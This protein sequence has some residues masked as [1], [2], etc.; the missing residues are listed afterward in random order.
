MNWNRAFKLHSFA[1]YFCS[2]GL[3]ALAFVLI[4]VPGLLAAECTSSEHA[5]AETCLK[6][7]TKDE[8]CRKV[9]SKGCGQARGSRPSDTCYE[10]KRNADS[11]KDEYY[12][13]CKEA[14]LSPSSCKNKM[15]VCTSAGEGDEYANDEDL[16][17]AFSEA[18][19]VPQDKIGSSCPKYSGQSFFDRKDKYQRDLDDI[20]KQLKDN[21]KELADLNKEFNDDVKKVQE[22]IAEAQKEYQEKQTEIKQNQRDRAADMAKSAADMAQNVRK[23]ETAILNK[24]QEIDTIY[25][26]K[27][28]SL[29]QITEA[30]SKR[31]CMAQ[32]REERKK[33]DAIKGGSLRSG[34]TAAA[35][36]KKQLQDLFDECMVKFDQAR[37]KLI[38]SSDA[39]IESAEKD[40]RNSQ[41]DIDSLQTQLTQMNSAEQQ[42][43]QDEA[44]TLT[45]AQTALQEKIQRATAELQSLQT[46]TQEKAKALTQEQSYLADKSKGISNQIMALGAVPNDETSTGKISDVANAHEAYRGAAVAAD[47]DGCDYFDEVGVVEKASKR[48]GGA[49]S[50]KGT[51]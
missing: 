20:N 47:M 46:T 36:K 23:L 7:D 34:F 45:N 18:L 2:L 14:G 15:N 19:G 27:N 4:P 40:I 42:A 16:L 33:Y 17:V 31:T 1:Q 37:M 6:Y 25:M 51:R 5:T 28:N 38:Q 48:S 29:A 30:A 10:S 35:L 43:Q 11:K 21:K 50:S 39:K 24:R 3:V 32:V 13:A 12:R 41:S 22:D 26:D 9:I 49:G 44:T 8:A